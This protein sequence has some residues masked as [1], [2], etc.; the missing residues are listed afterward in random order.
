MIVE[1]ILRYM[2]RLIKAQILCTIQE[3]KQMILKFKL[4]FREEKLGKVKVFST[5][6]DKL[7]I[8]KLMANKW[9]LNL[10]ENKL[11]I[12]VTLYRKMYNMTFLKSNRNKNR[13]MNKKVDKLE[14]VN[15]VNILDKLER[16]NRVNLKDKLERVNRV[17]IK[18]NIEKANRVKIKDNIEK[19]NRVKIKDN[20]EKANRVNINNKLMKTINLMK[21]DKHL[22]INNLLNK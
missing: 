10:I 2:I 5:L 8:L 4:L 11:E 20:I 21:Q 3:N 19:A 1:L 15:R 16:V 14:I 22:A 6:E 12:L 9:V 13:F 18:D 7:G 17:N